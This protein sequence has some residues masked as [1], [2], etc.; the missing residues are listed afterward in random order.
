MTK[1]QSWYF[2][3]LLFLAVLAGMV[4]VAYAT[5]RGPGVGGD[6]TIYLT[7]ARNLITGHGLGWT[8]ADGSF[9][10]L[11]YTPPF[12]PLA[13]SLVGLLVKDM[14][15][16]ARWLNVLLFGATIA[17][18]GWYFFHSTGR[19]WLAVLLSGIL[20]TS[21]V[22]IG[23]EVWAMSESIFLFLGFAGLIV[24][25]QY[26]ETPRAVTLVGS[27]LL[28]G[29]A[30]L[31]RYIGIAFVATG[32]LALLLLGQRNTRQVRLD[33]RWQSLRRALLFGVIAILPILAWLVIDFSLT[34]T[35]GSRSGQ[36]VSAYWQR[37]LEMGPA[38]QKIYIFWV[39]PDSIAAR[40]PRAAQWLLW[41]A[42]LVI[43]LALAAALTRRVG[44]SGRDVPAAG[45]TATRLAVL[46]GLFGVVYLVV[47]AVVQVFT[48]PPITLASRMLSPVHLAV[49]VLAFALLHLVL[50][51]FT[52]RSRLALAVA[53]LAC[54]A[55]FGIY[56][57]RGTAVVRGYHGA[58]I[59][60]M[61]PEW[62]ES[63]T[64]AA[65][66]NLDPKTPIITNETT[67]IMF[68][69]G[70]PA[71]TIQE[72]Y[73]DKPQA[74]FTPYGMGDDPGQRAFR[75]QGGALVL[76]NSTLRDDFAMYGNRV[77]E[78]IQA[79]LR[80]LT[81]YYQGDDGSIYFYK[82]QTTLTAS[83]CY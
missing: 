75:E 52:P 54:L 42:P 21:P 26:L 25:L 59:G 47:L 34:G 74:V 19:L 22:I 20:A 83:D 33:L 80:G 66:R 29:L 82:P 36:P 12:Y 10:L 11:P 16:G 27:A 15:A 60:Y 58:G 3:P 77:D 37:F 28:C 23:V 13:L 55:F 43:V 70:R 57:L 30:F 7:T 9:R 46:F 24:L 69:M 5:S 32:G 79:L 6:A 18:V 44:Q 56:T 39:V 71:Y 4:L 67:A 51:V 81:L 65:L 64:L 40:L 1:K 35:V 78:R 61:A 72:I 38:L 17:L 76:F 50:A 48:Y 68:F 49:I 14:V 53:A 73:Q 8:E 63:K 45:A 41:L 31:T 2:F 62:Q